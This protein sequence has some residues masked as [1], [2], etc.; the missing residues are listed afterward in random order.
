MKKVVGCSEGKVIFKNWF[1]LF[2]LFIDVVLYN[3]FGI[4]CKLVKYKII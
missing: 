3:F 1:Y 2:V 4:F